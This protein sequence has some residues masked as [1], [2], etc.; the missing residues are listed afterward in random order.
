MAHYAEAFYVQ[1]GQR[2]RFVH[3]GVG[4]AKHCP[5][6]MELLARLE[7]DGH[8]RTRLEPSV[9]DI[10]DG[11]LAYLLRLRFDADS[12]SGRRYVVP[13]AA[14]ASTLAPRVAG[15]YRSEAL[16]ALGDHMRFAFTPSRCPG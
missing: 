14:D 15:S 8:G 2:F 9:P 5:E 13:R 6:P 1:P 3:N 11:R 4:H 12:V 16:G 10:T 7:D